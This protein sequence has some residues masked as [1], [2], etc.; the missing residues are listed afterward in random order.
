[1]LDRRELLRRALVLVGGA[2]AATP[3]ELFADSAPQVRFFGAAQY[4]LVEAVVDIII[5]RTDTPGAIDAGVPASFDALMKNWASRERQEQ[6]RALLDEMDHAAREH[7]S[8]LVALERTARAEVVVAFDK[9]RHGDRIYREFKDLVLT[10]YCL[11]EVGATQVLRYE[12]VPGQWEAAVKMTPDTR[13]W[14]T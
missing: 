3:F 5:P 6:F 9:S 2:G 13:A 10:L 12:H 4:S 7:G 1:M 11:S 8:G 14:A